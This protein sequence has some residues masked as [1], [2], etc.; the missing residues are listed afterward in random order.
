MKTS[1]IFLTAVFA[2]ATLFTSCNVND[3]NGD[4]ALGV[5]FT[6]GI[7]ASQTKATI[8]GSGNSVWEA[9]D[10]VGIYMVGNGGTTVA[11]SIENVKYTAS[12]AGASTSFAST[13]T[14]IYY[15]VNT[16]AKVDFIAYHPYSASVSNW[17]YP[18][19]VATQTPQT[20]ID[21]MWAKA[22][23]VGVGYDKTNTSAV[24]FTFEHKLVKLVMNVSKGS[25]VTG[26]ISSVAIKGM[27]TTAN[28]DLTGVGGLTGA[29][30]AVTITPFTAT[31]ESKYE[32]ILLPVSTLGA[33]HT[34]EFTIGSETYTW[35]M[36]NEITSLAAG[37][38]YTYDITLT[39]YAVNATGSISKWTAGTPGTGIAD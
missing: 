9:G 15:P 37:S 23:N 34:V 10:P 11:E 17:V 6:S 14:V 8:D 4:N 13:G 2:T 30:G 22:N 26:N 33:S 38:I 31:A 32:A 35:K 12:A 29:D 19:N 24:D 39:K 36:S 5:K 16:P 7:T 25:G 27:N 20:N 1:K 28:F 18:V 21:L 3:D